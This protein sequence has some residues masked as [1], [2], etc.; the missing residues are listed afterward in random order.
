MYFRNEDPEMCETLDSILKDCVGL[1]EIAVYEAVLEKDSEY[2][3]CN[4]FGLTD[5]WHCKKSECDYYESKSGRGVCNNRGGLYSVGN[6]VTIHL[7]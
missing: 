1:N 2:V 3:W 5:R 6:P 7:Q 4:E